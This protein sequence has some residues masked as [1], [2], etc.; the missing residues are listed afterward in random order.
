MWLVNGEKQKIV[1]ID[2]KG[3][4]EVG[5]MSDPKIQFSNSI[6]DIEKEL[7]NE[8]IALNSFIL[9]PTYHDNTWWG[10]DYTE[11]QF[12]ENNVIFMKDYYF[13]K[14]FSKLQMTK[15]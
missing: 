5:G 9:T 10:N 15:S 8:K 11:D 4:R 12:L 14:I 1:F 7:A 3:I 2:P 13:Q 6:K